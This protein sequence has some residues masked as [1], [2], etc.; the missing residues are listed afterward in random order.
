M[1]ASVSFQVGSTGDVLR[2]PNAAL[3]Y[4]PQRDHVRPEDRP[5][6]EN[7]ATAAEVD[8]GVGTAA[9]SVEK[10]ELRRKR[11]IPVLT[12]IRAKS[13]GEVVEVLTALEREPFAKVGEPQCRIELAQLLHRPPGLIATSGTRIAGSEDTDRQRVVRL[14]CRCLFRP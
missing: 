12:R 4:Y 7:K 3:R 9:S 14:V 2:I 13:V 1:T 10:A 5:I 11:M 6:L 8:T